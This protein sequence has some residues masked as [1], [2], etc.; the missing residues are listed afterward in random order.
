MKK[1][2]A[3]VLFIS[4]LVS[5]FAFSQTLIRGPYLQTATSNS[6]TVRWRT[7][8]ALQGRVYYGNTAGNLNNIIDDSVSKTEHIINIGKLKAYTKYYYAIATFSTVLQKD[9]SDYFYTLPATGDTGTYRIGIFGDCGNNSINQRNVRDAFIKYLGNNYLNSWILLGDNAYANGFDEQ[10]Q[11]GFF[12]I[13]RAKLL[14]QSPL[15]PCPGNH[16]YDNVRTNQLSKN[17]PYYSIFTTPEKGEVG[18][19]ASNSKSYY[20][21]DLGNIHFI[22]LDSYGIELGQYRL[23]DTLSPQVN[24]LKNDLSSNKN[25]DWVVVFF[26]HPPY[27]MG[28]HNSDTEKE[29]VLIR[30]NLLPLLERYHV[31]VVLTGHSHVYERS[32]PMSGYYGL[33]NDF[34]DSYNISNST[35]IFDGSANSCP[36]IKDTNNRGTVY[37]VSGSAGQLGGQELTYPLFSNKYSNNTVGGSMMMEVHDNRLDVKWICTD[38]KIHDQFTIMKN[39][40]KSSSYTI[41][42]GETVKLTASYNASYDWNLINTHT[43]SVNIS[44][45]AGS[46]TIIVKDNFSCLHD[47]FFVSVLPKT[48]SAIINLNAKYLNKKAVE[49]NWQVSNENGIKTYQIER[50]VNNLNFINIATVRANNNTNDYIYTD[51]SN[52]IVRQIYYRIKSTDS[53]NYIRYSNSVVVNFNGLNLDDNI[54]IAP[55][56]AHSN[57]FRIRFNGGTGLANINVYDMTG[58]TVYRAALF[59][60]RTFQQ[61]LPALPKGVYVVHLVIDGDI[62]SKRIIVL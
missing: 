49:V 54:I 56:P 61:F 30:K 23:S 25:K 15:W 38:N 5:S 34:R 53:T 10:F 48:D 16:D 33:Q 60:N 1:G 35:G 42:E 43:K 20:S 11:T 18:G 21:F 13:Y 57:E 12:N 55:N 62:I 6:I 3:F 41:R 19:V 26:H 29:L 17:I 50:S 47:T 28:S 46:Y 59:L 58:R 24:W 39:V 37:V 40:N 22:S 51:S 8:T 4:L 44:P 32:A 2:F 36:Y 14:K 31:D 27:T 7:N 45:A 52:I 9:T